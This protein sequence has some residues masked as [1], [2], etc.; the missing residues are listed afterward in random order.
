MTLPGKIGARLY[1]NYLMPDRLSEYRTILQKIHDGGYRFVTVCDYATQIRSGG[2]RENRLC[3]VRID[4]DTDPA[5]AAQMFEVERDVGVRSTYYF[6]LSTIDRPLIER[7]NDHGSEVGYHCEELSMLVRRLGLRDQAE[8]ISLY[9]ELRERFHRNLERFRTDAGVA[10]RTTA[11]HGDF[12]NRRVGLNNNAF[13]DRE[14][15]DA[16]GIVAEAYEPWL[17]TRRSARA[18]DAPAPAWWH[19]APET[20]LSKKPSVLWLVLHPRYWVR[21]GWENT[22]EDLSRLEA[23][24]S[25]RWNRVRRIR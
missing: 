5:G 6:R 2:A 1:Q 4:V 8:I 20:A 23:E 18:V 19:R 15:L 24:L 12:L 10:P 3:I 7:M 25:Y 21:N 22:R 9:P 16:C 13:I 14:L 11:A 17:W